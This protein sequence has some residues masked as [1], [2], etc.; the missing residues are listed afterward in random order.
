MPN[1]FGDGF[2]ITIKIN[3]NEIKNNNSYVITGFMVDSGESNEARVCEVHMETPGYE[4]PNDNEM[5]INDDF[6]QIKVGQELVIEVASTFT[7]GEPANSSIVFTGFVERVEFYI[8]N[9][10]RVRC[11][12]HGMDAKMWMMANRLNEERGQD[13]NYEQ[14]IK[15]VI[16]NYSSQAQ[17]GKIALLKDVQIKNKFYQVN[18]SDYEFLCMLADLTGS[19]F[20]LSADGKINF[21]APSNLGSPSNTV[22]FKDGVV[23]IIRLSASVWGTVNTVQVTTLDP[24]DPSKTIVATSNTVQSIGSGKEPKQVV[25]QNC[26]SPSNGT[27]FMKI[28]DNSIETKEETQARADAEYN[29]RNL[30]FV[31]LEVLV[32][33]NPKLDVGQGVTLNGFGTPFNNNYIIVRLEH[34]WGTFSDDKVYVTKLY[35]VANKFTPQGR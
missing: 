35:L 10:G 18:Q 11:I 8:D 3:G 24:Q 28:T 20:Y 30:K 19:L 27:L 33:G 5:K 29:R 32:K 12:L 2:N 9:S 21:C 16:S 17:V 23:K 4:C 1:N 7:L 22:N 6:A 34:S 15:S 13:N 26:S 31:E 14:I 25:P